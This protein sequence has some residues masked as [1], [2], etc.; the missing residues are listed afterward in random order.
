MLLGTLPL[1][2]PNIPL[3]Y[4]SKI[5]VASPSNINSLNTAMKFWVRTFVFKKLEM[6]GIIYTLGDLLLKEPLEDY[7]LEPGAPLPPPSSLKRKILIKNK[8]YVLA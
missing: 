7:P 6:W 1:S 3:Y 8:R 4:L 5:T 2:L